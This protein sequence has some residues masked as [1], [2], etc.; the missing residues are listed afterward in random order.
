[1]VHF[2]ASGNVSLSQNAGDVGTPAGA[3]SGRLAGNSPIPSAKGGMLIGRV[4][5]GQPFAIGAQS[6]VTMPASGPLTLGINDDYV[7]DNKGNFTVN[8]R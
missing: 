2:D 6:D 1:V 4:T 5:N 3:N 8:I 7:Q